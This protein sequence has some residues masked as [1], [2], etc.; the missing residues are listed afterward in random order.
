VAEEGLAE[1]GAAGEGV[2]VADGVVLGEVA[3]GVDAGDAASSSVQAT[4]AV[5]AS[6][7]TPAHAIRRFMSSSLPSDRANPGES[8]GN[9]SRL[10][11]SAP[12]RR[13]IP[14]YFSY[15]TECRITAPY[16]EAFA[17]KGVS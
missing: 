6:A 1:E 10:G 3:L 2:E 5:I 4:A 15:P 11:V 8:S 9:D 13:V 7:A 17:R 14:R 12:I 16:G